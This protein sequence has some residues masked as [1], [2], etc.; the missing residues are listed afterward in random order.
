MIT[1]AQFLDYLLNQ[2]TSGEFI[3]SNLWRRNISEWKTD[4]FA[5]LAPVLMLMASHPLE[6]NFF[7][8]RGVLFRILLFIVLAAFHYGALATI[9]PLMTL[10]LI[11]I[12]PFRNTIKSDVSTAT[13]I[14]AAIVSSIF[15]PGT[16]YG[17]ACLLYTLWDS[18]MYNRRAP[19]I[20]YRRNL[21]V[22]AG[23]TVGGI[24]WLIKSK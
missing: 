21:I 12:D 19:Q 23:I 2:F 22:S 7:N 15:F 9:F 5:L 8:I 24:L 10:I 14:V 13:A 16:A 20:S 3:W 1:L 18:I 4:P 11:L 6:S 17:M